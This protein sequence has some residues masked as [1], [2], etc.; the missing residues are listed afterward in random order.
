MATMDRG[1]SPSSSAA[2]RTLKIIGAAVLLVPVG[3]IALL[4]VGDMTNG[5]P[6]AVLELLPAVP[7]LLLARLGWRHPRSGGWVLVGGSI[8]LGALWTV[9]TRDMVGW[10]LDRTFFQGVLVIFVPPL[11]AGLLLLLAARTEHSPATTA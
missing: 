3:V 11:L 9:W 6:W 4:A 10:T 2:S 5:D 7:L 8:V 1:R